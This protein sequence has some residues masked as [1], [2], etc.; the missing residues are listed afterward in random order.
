MRCSVSTVRIATLLSLVPVGVGAHTGRAGGRLIAG[1]RCAQY[2]R[3]N[4]SK[5]P[6][7]TAAVI[8]TLEQ[9]LGAA[10]SAVQRISLDADGDLSTD[11]MLQG[12][13]VSNENLNAYLIRRHFEYKR[14]TKQLRRLQGAARAAGG[15]PLAA[16]IAARTTGVR[17]GDRLHDLLD[18]RGLRNSFSAALVAGGVLNSLDAD[19]GAFGGVADGD[20]GLQQ[21]AQGYLAWESRHLGAAAD[22]VLEANLRGRLGFVPAVALLQTDTV[23]LNMGADSVTARF[24]DA[25]VWTLGLQINR[26]VSSVAE[27]SLVGLIGQTRL[28]TTS[29]IVERGGERILRLSLVDNDARTAWFGEVG[30][31]LNVFDNPLEVLHAEND[32]LSPLFLLSTGFKRDTRFRADGELL[33]RDA[34][35]DRFYFRFMIDA[36]KVVDRRQLAEQSRTF[37]VGFGVEYERSWIG[38]ESPIPSS[39][40]F[41]L[42]GDLDFLQALRGR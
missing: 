25:F 2:V 19:G 29:E 8:N 28:N 32:F 26:P 1:A 6:A 33:R 39:T 3:D 10:L 17:L 36:L 27:L 24:K 23:A 9:C 16:H 15:T 18:R 31:Q 4:V 41:M 40:R 38:D 12:V 35:Q 20:D 34:N 13:R 30:L 21:Q 7:D 14:L 11:L 42:R 37:T 5:T 22:N